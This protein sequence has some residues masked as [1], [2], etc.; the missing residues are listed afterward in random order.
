MVQRWAH[1]QR[2]RQDSSADCLCRLR[3]SKEEHAL[4]V[5]QGM[6]SAKKAGLEA[7]Q[8]LGDGTLCQLL[9]LQ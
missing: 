8:Q 4:L 5:E 9:T 7:A 6:K 1:K 2:R 3:V